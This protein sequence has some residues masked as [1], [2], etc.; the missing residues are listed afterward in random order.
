M[1]AYP[2]PRAHLL[3]LL[4]RCKEVKQAWVQRCDNS[5]KSTSECWPWKGALFP[6]GYGRLSVNARLSPTGKRETLRAHGLSRA[7][8]DGFWPVDKICCH[9]C[10]IPSCVNPHHLYWGTP[11]TNHEDMMARG[12]ERL[13]GERHGRTAL[14][15]K[16]VVAI[17]VAYMMS[18][19]QTANI[20]EAFNVPIHIVYSIGRRESWKLVTEKIKCGER[21]RPKR[22]LSIYARGEAHGNSKTT[23]KIVSKIYSDY[24]VKRKNRHQICA[25]TGVNYK[26]VSKIVQKQLWRHLTNNISTKNSLWD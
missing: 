17:F 23:T 3:A 25:E 20:A 18:G 22:P 1:S 14:T 6:S 24:F 11:K 12:R 7:L 9:S 8:F 26:H 5:Q 21:V 10:D 16:T 4:L 19:E 15:N 13:R 2:T